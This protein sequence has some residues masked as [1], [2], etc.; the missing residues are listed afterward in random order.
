MTPSWCY[1]SLCIEYFS[2]LHNSSFLFLA[3]YVYWS[4]ISS[5]IIFAF[6]L[7][8]LIKSS[9]NKLKHN[10]ALNSDASRRLA[11]VLAALCKQRQCV[12]QALWRFQHSQQPCLWLQ[13][14]KACLCPLKLHPLSQRQP[15]QQVGFQ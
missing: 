2:S 11:S 6:S 5:Q 4:V 3:S 12:S 13:Q 9:I 1:V 14:C 10:N 8:C 15:P 7:M